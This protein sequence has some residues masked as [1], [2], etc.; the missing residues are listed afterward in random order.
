MYQESFIAHITAVKKYSPNT[1]LAYSNDLESFSSFLATQYSIDNPREVTKPMVRSWIIYLINS[2]ISKVSIKRKVSTLNSYFKYLQKQEVVKANPVSGVITP[3]LE[4]KL[5]EY[6]T[7]NKIDEV[8]STN[9][10]EDDYN[11]T[12]AKVII[13][14]LFATG[15]RR[16]EMIE[17]K[18]V[19]VDFAAATIKV[20]G[21]RNKQRI[22]PVHTQ[23][24]EALKLYLSIRPSTSI[25]NF[26]VTEKGNK[27][28]PKL[29]YNLVTQ[30]L[31]SVTSQS[32]KSPH[33]LRH[34]FATNMLNEGADINSIKE[35]LGHQSL[36]ATQVY[37]HNSIEKLK[38]QHKQAHPRA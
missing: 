29:I 14:L 34:S 4:K 15:I 8:L 38:K 20:L 22:V 19:D 13:E 25:D 6:I 3:K 10:L 17:L 32:K 12:L 33:I 16:A 7:G 1:V 37:T 21:K 35:I 2:G 31:N 27:I 30:T 36:A 18:V 28:Y 24:M 11:K 26:F 23:A 5:P 9:N